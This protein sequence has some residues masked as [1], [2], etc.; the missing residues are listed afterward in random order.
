MKW[1]AQVL[2]YVPL[3]ALVGYFST[4][5]RFSAIGAGEALVRLSFIHSA[6]R[7]Y[8]CRT[9]SP[10]ELAKLA[11][12][13]RAQLDCPRERSDLL[14]E[15][16]MDGRPLYR[17]SVR[18]GGLRND[19]PSTVYRRLEVPAGRHTFRTRLADTASGEFRHHGEATVDLAPGRVLIIDFIASKGGFAFI[20]SP[21]TVAEVGKKS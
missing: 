8:P 9:R 17:I 3:M 10:E 14:M 7:R 12:N 6:E 20:S 1:I 11:P 19:L 4:E 21:G 5:P 16:E 18:P 13:M 2:L 15:V